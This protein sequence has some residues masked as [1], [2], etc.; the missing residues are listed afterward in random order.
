MKALFPYD[1][2]VRLARADDPDPGAGEAL[3]DVG[4]FSVNRGE[5]LLLEDPP[6]GWRPGKD[7]AG[8]V[9]A[10]AADGSGPP[11]G[12]RVVGHARSAGWA[13]YVAV[14]ATALAPLP[15]GLAETTAATL[16]LA[17]LTALR[18]L[19]AAG[20]LV[21]GRLLLTGASGGVGHYVT[22]LAIAAGACVTAV[23]ATE[24][25]G[26]RLREF[27]ARTV[28]SVQ[29]A[30]GW[31]DVAM[32]SVGGGSLAAVRRKVRPDGRIIWFGQASREPVTLD[33][34]DWVQGTAGAPIV[35]FHYDGD[36]DANGADL[37]TLVR[38]VAQDRL[39]PEI[40]SLRPWQEAGLTIADLRRRRVRGNAVLQVLR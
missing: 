12:T 30:Q 24:D 8:T 33:F 10:A 19:R 35:Q 7:V 17:G 15:D 21:G 26:S 4:A 22:E 5:T 18:L 1:G 31:F 29:A 38:L 11:A 37:A 6:I 40:G 20:P 28:T 14:P 9:V 16:P 32:E 27:G 2:S 13:E 3:F 23:C 39:H 34:F 36:D 25:R